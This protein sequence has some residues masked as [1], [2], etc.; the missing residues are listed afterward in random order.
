VIELDYKK[1]LKKQKFDLA[2]TELKKMNL[3]EEE[4]AKKIG[5][6]YSKKGWWH[7]AAGFYGEC[8]DKENAKKLVDK[9]KEKEDF[10]SASDIAAICGIPEYYHLKRI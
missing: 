7:L 1:L 8:K 5:D 2:I 6:F 10:I 9:L 4:I 3:S